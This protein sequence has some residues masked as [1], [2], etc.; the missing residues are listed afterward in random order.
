MKTYKYQ[1]DISD[2]DR[3]EKEEFYDLM[4]SL[5]EV[6]YII[7]GDNSCI[8]K[9]NK[10]C[11]RKIEKETK[12]IKELIKLSKIEE[13]IKEIIENNDILYTKTEKI[14]DSCSY[15]KV[16]AI[17]NCELINITYKVA[18]VLK[19]KLHPNGIRVCGIGFNREFEL[20]YNLSLKLFEDGYYIRHRTI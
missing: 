19:E 6:D 12:R 14:T 10:A 9:T 5:Q 2:L 17:E 16:F 3:K 11:K 20:I 7:E 8:V 18:R 15:I 13:E 4:N 1:I